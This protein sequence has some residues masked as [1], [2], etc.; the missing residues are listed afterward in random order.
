MIQ[1][2][3]WLYVC[4]DKNEERTFNRIVLRCSICAFTPF[5]TYCCCLLIKCWWVV[6]RPYV[7]IQLWSLMIH[8]ITMTVSIVWSILRF[9]RAKL[10]KI[11]SWWV[12]TLLK[13]IVIFLTC[14]WVGKFVMKEHK[15]KVKLL[16]QIIMQQNVL[17][18]Y[19][20]RFIR[21]IHSVTPC[22]SN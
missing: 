21:W 4:P 19:I 17:S 2:V 20:K 12:E 5:C 13:I 16:I 3:Q 15:D 18:L 14:R 10:V 9:R 8:L 1:R 6:W 7:L 22:V 11:C